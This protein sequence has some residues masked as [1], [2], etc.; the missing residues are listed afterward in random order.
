MTPTQAVRKLAALIVSHFN[1]RLTDIEQRLA[2]L[3]KLSF[4]QRIDALE[5]KHT[6]VEIPLDDECD[7]C[8]GIFFHT[9]DCSKVQP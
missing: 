2:V 8:G 7:E 4:D 6:R 3:E 5:S 1:P 9:N